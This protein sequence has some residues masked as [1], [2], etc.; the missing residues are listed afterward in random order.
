MRFILLLGLVSLFADI[1]YEGARSITGPYLSLLGASAAAVGFVSGL[2]EFIGYAL[3][4]FSGYLADRTRR[5]W[6]I[7]IIG[8]LL[9]LIA[10]P[11]LAIAGRWEIAGFFIVMERLG[12][13]IRT[14]SRDTMLSHA[15]KQVGR[16]WGFGIHEAMDQIGAILGPLFTSLVLYLKLGYREGFTLLA[17]PAVLALV[18]LIISRINFP[19]PQEL[20]TQDSD[21]NNKKGITGIFW[22]YNAFIFLTIMGFASFALISFHFKTMGVVPDVQIPLL[23]ALAMGIDAIFALVVG[24]LYDR[25]GFKILILTPLLSLS[26]PFLVFSSS[27]FLALIGMILWGASMGIQETILRAAIAD[28][29]SIS[30]RG[31]G[32]GIF[33]TSYGFALLLGGSLMG[34]LYEFSLSYLCLFIVL[35]QAVSIPFL[36]T[37][38]KRARREN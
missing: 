38:L 21:V 12:K 30:R 17:I 23:Y 24:R 10:V 37:I 19:R 31:L 16:G 36:W 2:G 15:T 14:P 25:L 26:L 27:Y 22:I 1:T 13:A 18:C 3:R 35:A 33:N 20:E 5:Y 29:T 7:T 6:L 11:L 28:L 8:Y 34:M 32:Y 4:L 9:N